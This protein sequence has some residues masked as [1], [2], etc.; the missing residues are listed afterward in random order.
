[1]QE[2]NSSSE[3]LDRR[4][5]E[6]EHEIE[7]CTRFLER[8]L[9]ENTRTFL[10]KLAYLYKSTADMKYIKL[11]GKADAAIWHSFTEEEL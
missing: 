2:Y 9:D 4:I 5:A 8:K 11:T 1:M 3:N 7:V 6:N 10:S